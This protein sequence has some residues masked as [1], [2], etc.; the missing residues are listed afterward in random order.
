MKSRP[1]G[2]AFI[3]AEIIDLKPH[4]RRS[5]ISRLLKTDLECGGKRSPL[6]IR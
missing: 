6:W 2:P 4:L 5:T 1:E 3:Y